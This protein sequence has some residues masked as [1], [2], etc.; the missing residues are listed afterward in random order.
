MATI[1]DELVAII[2]LDPKNFNKGR[3][4]VSDGLK[5]TRDETEA[6]GKSMEAFG[7]R[8]A[9]ALSSLRNEAIGLFLAFQGASSLGSY[10]E[11]ILTGDAATGRLAKN[12]NMSTNELSA[13]QLAVKSLGGDAKDANAD[14]SAMANA[15]QS[16]MLTGNTGHD[17][18]FKALGVTR[19]D[20]SKPSQALLKMAEAGE[21]MGKPEFYARLQRIGISEAGI[22]LLEKGRKGVEELVR[23][24]ERDGAASEADAEKA[25][26][27]QAKLAELENKITAVVRPALY[28]LVDGLNDLLDGVNGNAAAIPIL[29]GVLGAVVIV[30]GTAAA[31]FIA[32]AAA[33][34]GVTYAMNE[35]I[36]TH[37]KLRSFLDDIEAP[38]KNYLGP[39]WAWLFD[40]GPFG[41]VHPGAGGSGDGF[42]TDPN[43]G[44]I[45]N[46][47]G[48]S[49]YPGLNK[50]GGGSGGVTKPDGSFIEAELMR[51]GFTAAQARGIHAGITAEGGGVG[52]AANGAFGVGQWRGTRQKALFAKYGKNPNMAQQMAF[53][54]SE[55]K[56]G[57]RGGASV[58][59]S[60]S[61]EETL[62]NYVGGDDW[63]FMRPGSGRAGD[64]RR[65]MAFLGSKGYARL[66]R[67]R[68]PATG[69]T[70][71]NV[72]STN[73]GTIIVNTAATDAEGIA[74]DLPGAIKRRGLTT[75]AN[76]GLE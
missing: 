19:D 24:K 13:W 66:S 34:A 57:D 18:D 33:I 51:N 20:L 65:G 43:T 45:S 23:A 53:L 46:D 1:I 37:P 68:A 41:D 49:I 3:G 74:R 71:G 39:K 70:G 22:N 63:G 10:V 52:L 26:K 76:R 42:T 48:A 6:T 44:F 25:A 30:A 27:F 40:R 14:L 58:M 29:T 2:T 38:L 4:Q 60:G 67:P 11:N 47:Y 36:K 56:G 59:A 12:I 50:L 72:S 55:L 64:M 5:K 62:S 21:R 15:F 54:I 7:R 9:S 75:Q 61:A 17:A 73:V 28:G 16:Y 32:W 8:T 35:L 69:A 31:P